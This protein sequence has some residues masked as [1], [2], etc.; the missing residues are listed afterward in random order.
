MVVVVEYILEMVILVLWYR[1][2][3]CE[4]L[5][6]KKKLVLRNI[7]IFVAQRKNIMKYIGQIGEIDE[8]HKKY[9]YNIKAHIVQICKKTYELI[10]YIIFAPIFSM[11]I[12]KAFGKNYGI[13]LT[14]IIICLGLVSQ[15]KNDTQ[16]IINSVNDYIENVMI[17]LER[18]PDILKV[19][20]E[21]HPLK[22][23]CN[24]KKVLKFIIVYL[25]TVSL[26]FIVA[27]LLKGNKVVGW[28]T[29][30]IAV[31]IVIRDETKNSR[32]KKKLLEDTTQEVLSVEG[33]ILE[34]NRDRIAE[35]ARCLGIKP[36][37]CRMID[38]REMFAN[39]KTGDGGVSEINISCG[40]V[41]CID[42]KSEEPEEVLMMI[43]AHELAHL[44]YKD[45]KKLKK[46]IIA[47]GLAFIL[48]EV[49]SVAGMM[50]FV[51]KSIH[52]IMWCVLFVL[53]CCLGK[54][55]TD[56][57]YWRQ[58]AELRADRLA[59]DICKADKQIIIEFWKHY[60][61]TE[62]KKTNIVDQF[63][64]KYIKVEGHPPIKRRMELIEKRNKWYWWEYFEHA[65]LILKWRLTNKGW[66]G[67]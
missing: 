67:R 42:Q 18:D 14:I 6:V 19:R 28:L 38:T 26:T 63:Y 20:G 32:I 35:M 41:Q 11:I 49:A 33:Y 47:S 3:L 8:V 50:I 34:E 56:E 24:K 39:S 13:V 15:L 52:I 1:W 22:L 62:E 40:L 4:E 45:L 58:I 44:Y 10:G 57:R 29:V 2:V 64:I 16:P 59:I 46:R 31:F 61:V 37:I 43:I 55:M 12:M 48:L 17:P 36:L 9:F 66:N 60:G 23:E 65:I 51:K 25:F 27:Y 30:P 54:I 21:D 5:L 53:I 7:H